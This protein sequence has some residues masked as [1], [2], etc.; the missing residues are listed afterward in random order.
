M[1]LVVV[2]VFLEMNQNVRYIFPCNAQSGIL[3]PGELL[4]LF[5][6]LW[7]GSLRAANSGSLMFH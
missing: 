5:L 2:P 4:P 7:G 6:T 1:N 3:G